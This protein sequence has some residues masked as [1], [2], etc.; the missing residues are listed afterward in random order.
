[1]L[2]QALPCFSRSMLILIVSTESLP[3]GFQAVLRVESN[4]E[5]Q[6]GLVSEPNS[7]GGALYRGGVCNYIGHPNEAPLFYKN[8]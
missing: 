6:E 8:V 7:M 5:G 1:M 2:S 4:I 3:A